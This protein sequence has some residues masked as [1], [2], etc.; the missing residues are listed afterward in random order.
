M[1][2]GKQAGVRYLAHQPFADRRGRHH[3]HALVTS[4]LYE[5]SSAGRLLGQYML[6][7]MKKMVF[8]RPRD[9]MGCPAECSYGLGLMRWPTHLRIR[10]AA[11]AAF[12]YAVRS[13]ST[14]TVSGR[15][16]CTINHDPDTL[17]KPARLHLQLLF[18]RLIAKAYCVGT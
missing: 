4:P 17:A 8:A 13:L 1:V 9:A 6:K 2:F 5:V 18:D 12:G 10:L 16:R 15:S 7:E 11:T 14:E 3:L